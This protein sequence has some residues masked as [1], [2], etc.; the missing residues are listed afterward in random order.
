MKDSRK[1]SSANPYSRALDLLSRRDHSTAEIRRKLALRDF[2][3]EEIS[4]TVDRLT[5]NGLLDDSR[6]AAR[7]AESRVRNGRGYG[8]RIVQELIQRGVS[9]DIASEAAAMAFAEH[10]EDMQLKA[11]VSKKYASFNPD[12][13]SLKERN[14]VFAS[15]LRSGFSL[16]SITSFFKNRELD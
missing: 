13:A 12:E 3:V 11:L 1:D 4:L 14:R 5:E 7:W 16:Q 9:R 15:L 10:P 8:M 6:F 2:T